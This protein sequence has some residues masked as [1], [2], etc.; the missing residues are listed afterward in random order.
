MLLPGHNFYQL[1]ENIAVQRSNDSHAWL[2]LLLETSKI[3]HPVN[4]G[5]AFILP[6]NR[7]LGIIAQHAYMHNFCSHPLL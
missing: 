3:L 1:T 7:R 4:T 6:V 2:M 5:P